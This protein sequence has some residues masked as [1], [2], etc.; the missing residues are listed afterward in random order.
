MYY[1]ILLQL[2]AADDTTL[3]K[4]I[5]QFAQRGVAVRRPVDRLLHH[6][7]AASGDFRTAE[8]LYRR[9]LSIPI[10]PSLTN[11]EQATVIA[12]CRELLPPFVF[13]P[14]S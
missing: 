14:Q 8:D 4:L 7:V 1:R 11:D 3:D 2:S 6:L 12:A 13:A 10:Y 9:T 5:T